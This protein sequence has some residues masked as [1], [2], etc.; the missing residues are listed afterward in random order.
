MR[1]N[2]LSARLIAN[3]WLAKN[4]FE[5]LGADLSYQEF[6][7]QLRRLTAKTVVPAVFV[8]RADAAAYIRGF[9]QQNSRGAA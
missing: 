9:A 8:S 3:E 5:P 2:N 1:M 6:A 4:G 7:T